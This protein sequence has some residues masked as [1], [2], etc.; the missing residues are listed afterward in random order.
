MS[1]K[2]STNKYKLYLKLV[3]GAYMEKERDR[4]AEKGYPSP[5]QPDHAS[6]E[7]AIMMEL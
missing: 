4:A 1:S 5:I 3:R 2:S 6:S 7:L